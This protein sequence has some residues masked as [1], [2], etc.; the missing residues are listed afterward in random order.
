MIKP[1]QILI[2]AVKDIV[3]PL[4][5]KNYIHGV[6]IMNFCFGYMNEVEFAFQHQ[7]SMHLN[8]CFGM[9]ELCPQENI[10]HKSIVVESKA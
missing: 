1:F 4:F 5:H 3:Y 8:P 7:K 9:A 2:S 6:H 10:Q